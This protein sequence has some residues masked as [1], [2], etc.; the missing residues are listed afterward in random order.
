MISWVWS[1]TALT[2]PFGLSSSRSTRMVPSRLPGLTCLPASASCRSVTAPR[3]RSSS[4]SRSSGLVDDA[5]T[6]RPSWTCTFFPTP[7]Q[8]SA[9]VPVHRLSCT[10]WTSSGTSCSARLP[11]GFIVVSLLTRPSAGQGRGDP[12]AH[13][14]DQ[15]VAVAVTVALRA[16]R[17]Q[18]PHPHR[19]WPD[20]EASPRHQL[21]RALERDGDDAAARVHAHHEAAFLEGA[22]R[23]RPAPRA[24]GEYDEAG[25]ALQ[26]V[27]G[28]GDGARGLDAVRAIHLDEPR[29]AEHAAEEG[30]VE[31]LLLGHGPEVDSQ[32]LEEDGRVEV[33]HVVG[34]DH[35]VAVIAQQVPPLDHDARPR[36]EERHADPEPGEAVEQRWR[37]HEARD[38]V[39]GEAGRYRVRGEE[40][41]DE[42]GPDH[43]RAVRR[44]MSR[45]GSG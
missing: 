43:R 24:L 15:G 44:R 16:H 17:V 10:C 7:A 33:A 6:S 30:D 23:A 19:A 36:E 1:V 32:G 41:E 18:D 12:A 3:R 2:R 37:S 31:D 29:E 38:A 13:G 21:P 14:G 20:A 4:P 9:R 39:A 22:E 35:G 27:H 25:A 5:K 45:R 34:H 8:V 42:Q 26:G 40:D 11:S 28:A